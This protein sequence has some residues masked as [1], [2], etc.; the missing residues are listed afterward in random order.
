[1]FTYGQSDVADP[2]IVET[3]DDDD[4][5]EDDDDQKWSYQLFLV[6]A[7][8]KKTSFLSFGEMTKVISLTFTCG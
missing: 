6:S 7:Y 8:I 4:D 3:R 5:D 2:N 1:M